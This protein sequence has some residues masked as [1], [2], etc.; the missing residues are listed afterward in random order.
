MDDT[1]EDFLEKTFPLIDC[2]IRTAKGVNQHLEEK[3]YSLSYS[4]VCFAAM[5]AGNSIYLL[6]KYYL[7]KDEFWEKMGRAY[8]YYDPL[9]K[10]WGDYFNFSKS[11]GLKLFRLQGG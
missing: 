4:I 5:A 3:P 9:I 6:E 1:L 8:C 10:S 2:S 11:I 7:G